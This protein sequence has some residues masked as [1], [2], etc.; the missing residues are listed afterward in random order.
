[1]NNANNINIMSLVSQNVNMN[2][3]YST[4]FI[5]TYKFHKEIKEQDFFYRTQILQL[6]NM[7]DWNDDL[8][9]KKRDK[10]FDIMCS[11]PRF[12]DFLNNFNKSDDNFLNTFL[13][14]CS[15]DTERKKMIFTYLF[16]FD[17]FDLTHMCICDKINI[18]V[19]REDNMNK[20]QLNIM[21]K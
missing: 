19:V 8:I 7:N 14:F 17:L 12:N 10:L 3:E 15:N 5:C 6:F 16:S 13:I 20:L 9:D 11:D 4:D 21:K 2:K 18:G 1:M